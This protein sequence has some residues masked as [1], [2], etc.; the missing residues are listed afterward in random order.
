MRAHPLGWP[1]ALHPAECP[2]K[3]DQAK[4]VRQ[5]R[6]S[7]EHAELVEGYRSWREAAE[8]AAEAAS[9]GYATELADYWRTAGG[10][11]TFRR[12]LL[13]RPHHEGV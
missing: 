4:G 1:R 2:C 7:R 6:C 9:A 11:P 5:H 8:Q 3:V 13:H 12:Y 10:A